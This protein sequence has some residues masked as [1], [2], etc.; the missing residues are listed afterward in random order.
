M[1]KLTVEYWEDFLTKNTEELVA[2]DGIISYQEK[3]LDESFLAGY[4]LKRFTKHGI[5]VVGENLS[6]SKRASYCLN[7]RL[8]SQD[9]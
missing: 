3:T 2:E 4:S 6:A 1:N 9:D 5:D 8:G 7:G